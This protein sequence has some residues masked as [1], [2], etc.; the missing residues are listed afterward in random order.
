MKN[1]S[2]TTGNRTRNLPSCSVV[3]Q[4]S[5]PPRAPSFTVKHMQINILFFFVNHEIPYN[6]HFG[7]TDDKFNIIVL[8]FT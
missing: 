2:D 5:A 8:L 6:K 7:G 1:T 4:P 3:P